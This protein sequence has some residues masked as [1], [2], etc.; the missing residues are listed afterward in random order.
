MTSKWTQDDDGE[1]EA[2]PRVYDCAIR[3]YIGRSTVYSGMNA[4]VYSAWPAPSYSSCCVTP[5]DLQ[6]R[7]RWLGQEAVKLCCFEGLPQPPGYCSWLL[8]DISQ[9]PIDIYAKDVRH[10]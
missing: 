8:F 6:A 3:R 5:T 1:I 10:G 4:M 2:G 9:L 7:P